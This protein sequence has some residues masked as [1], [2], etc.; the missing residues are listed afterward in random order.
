MSVLWVLSMNDQLSVHHKATIPLWFAIKNRNDSHSHKFSYAEN[1]WK[2][3]IYY[4]KYAELGGNYIYKDTNKIMKKFCENCTYS[5]SCT[6]IFMGGWCQH[7][8]TNMG[9]N[10]GLSAQNAIGCI[11]PNTITSA[12]MVQHINFFKPF[13]HL[14]FWI[15]YSKICDVRHMSWQ[16]NMW[17]QDRT[18][19]YFK[20]K[21]VVRPFMTSHLSSQ[22]KF[23]LIEVSPDNKFYCTINLLI[24][25]L[26]PF[27][28]SS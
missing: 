23:S 2:N 9:R 25:M 19:W 27:F 21:Y 12:K 14:G 6:L 24:N 5:D 17:R 20:Y 4:S 8:I 22:D 18:Y 3:I 28:C 16:E 11:P 26:S 1:I 7:S 15:E 13:I 10:M